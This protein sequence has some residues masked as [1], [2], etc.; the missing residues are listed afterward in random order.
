MRSS[1]KFAG[2]GLF[3]A[4]WEARGNSSAKRL[5]V[6][7]VR[8][9]VLL[10]LL[11][12]SSLMAQLIPPNDAGVTMGRIQLIV[13]DVDAQQR[14]WVD[15]IGGTIVANQNVPEI[16]FPGVYIQLRQGE[17]SGPSAGSVVDHFG[18]VIKDLPAARVKWKANGLAQTQSPL[19]S[20][21]GYV[22]GP[23]GVRL[24][25]FGEPTLRTPVQ[26]NHVHFRIPEKEIPK[27]QAWYAKMFG[28]MPGTRESVSRP[29][30][31]MATDDLPG[32]INLSLAPAPDLLA[33]TK[34]R[35]IDHIGFEVKNL[36]AFCR[37]LKSE[38]VEFEGPVQQSASSKYLKEAF[39]TDPWG[40]RIELTEGLGRGGK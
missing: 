34:G 31:F 3:P 29:G 23:E 28:W 2:S 20:N 32:N 14:F 5:M 22:T 9:I 8:T 1:G 40:A 21:Q 35:F 6:T 37:K 27:I 16:E 7:S 4:F 24:E 19:N 18:F 12:G 11:A 30:N 13:K 36:E 15:M 17:P 33:P 38:G 25:V 26:M 39:L 10:S